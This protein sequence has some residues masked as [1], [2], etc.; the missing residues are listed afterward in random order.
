M[1]FEDFCTH[2]E[3]VVVCEVS[4]DWMKRFFSSRFPK[5]K[6]ENSTAFKF[7]VEFT[8]AYLNL[9]GEIHWEEWLDISEYIAVPVSFKH[10]VLEFA[11]LDSDFNIVFHYTREINVREIV[12][13][14][15]TFDSFIAKMVKKKRDY[16]NNTPVDLIINQYI[17]DGLCLF[18]VANFNTRNYRVNFGFTQDTTKKNL[19]T[20]RSNFDDFSVL[21]EPFSIQ[22]AF[23]CVYKDPYAECLLG[24]N[25]L[26]YL[27]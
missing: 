7:K 13:Q 16:F 1:N 17:K 4:K 22:V 27:C 26:P 8:F 20:S 15:A 10:K 19:F 18:V 21:V 24:I 3:R 12:L 14:P 2:L 11:R 23:F 9:T 25:Y 5:S 6:R